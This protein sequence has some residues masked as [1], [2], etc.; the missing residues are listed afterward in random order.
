MTMTQA[1]QCFT[2]AMLKVGMTHRKTISFSHEDVAK[3][4]ALS[5]DFNAI[6]SDPEAA[7][8]RFPDAREIIVPG[9]LIQIAVTGIFGSDFPGDGCLGLTFVPERIRAPVCPGDTID[10]ELTVT[11]IRGPIIE[12]DVTMNQSNGTRALNAT[13]RL[14]PADEAYRAWWE[15]RQT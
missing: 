12:L 15:S 8:L 2:T 13:A 7:K 14:M 10:V 1:T 9:G 6:H 3:Y 11:K 5:G 4:C